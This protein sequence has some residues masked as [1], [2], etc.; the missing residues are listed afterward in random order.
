MIKRGTITF[1][2]DVCGCEHEYANG[3][4]HYFLEDW[5]IYPIIENWAKDTTLFSAQ[6][7]RIPDKELNNYRAICKNC[8]NTIR[9]AV[10]AE[11][12]FVRLRK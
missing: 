2:C 6:V 5:T 11:L 3:Y 1:A 4:E 12:E 9:G 7:S 8:C 10:D